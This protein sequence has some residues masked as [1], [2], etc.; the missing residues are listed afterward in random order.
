MKRL[1]LALLLLAAVFWPHDEANATACT[2]GCSQFVHASAFSG[3]APG[4][5]ITGV[6]A[7]DS[8]H[9]WYCYEGPTAVNGVTVGGSATGVQIG[10][11]TSTGGG[12]FCG[13]AVKAN[14]ASG[15]VAIV[16]N[17]IGA[18]TNCDTWVSEWAGE[19]TSSSLAAENSTYTAGSSS[20]P[21]PC[22]S[23]T[24]GAGDTIEAL[25]FQSQS[26]T[27]TSSP[28]GYSASFI[29]STYS[30]GVFKT[31]ASAGASNPT[32]TGGASSFDNSVTCASFT[33]AGGGGAVLHNRTMTGA[34]S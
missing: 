30:F 10:A 15:S 6:T 2:G 24:S 4:V 7:G 29:F 21:L 25:L 27:P 31:A 18:C 5:T 26:V 14:S 34:G 13:M 19:A 16:V 20:T 9:I 23:I 8:L 17:T 22:G 32:Y 3:T 28:A 12:H 11:V 33:Q 1:F